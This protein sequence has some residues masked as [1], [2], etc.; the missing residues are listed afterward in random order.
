MVIHLRHAINY[1]LV[2]QIPS[3]FYIDLDPVLH[4]IVYVVVY[5]VVY[6]VVYFCIL[7]HYWCSMGKSTRV[8]TVIE[9]KSRYNLFAMTTRL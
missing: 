7:F 4:L 3:L 6:I 8:L 5:I 2:L 1:T 9:Y